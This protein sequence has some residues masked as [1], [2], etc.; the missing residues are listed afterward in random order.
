MTT[1]K[2]AERLLTLTPKDSAEAAVF[3]LAVLDIPGQDCL[4]PLS[5]PVRRNLYRWHLSF[6]SAFIL[7]VS[8]PQV[9][10]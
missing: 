2:G 3:D 5:A 7:W 10:R 8:R 4:I 6:G 9:Y 1:R